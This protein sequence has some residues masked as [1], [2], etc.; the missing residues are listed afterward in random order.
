MAQTCGLGPIWLSSTPS[1]VNFAVE[2]EQCEGKVAS[3]TIYLISHGTDEANIY[4]ISWQPE[5]PAPP[6]YTTS[7]QVN[8]GL[9]PTE[10]REGAIDFYPKTAGSFFGAMVVEYGYNINALN[11]M[12]ACL[13]DI[14]GT[15]IIRLQHLLEE[16]QRDGPDFS[17]AATQ[18]T[19]AKLIATAKYNELDAKKSQAE[20]KAVALALEKERALRDIDLG[21]FC[22][23]CNRS[24]TQIE[25]ED[26]KSFEEHLI[27]VH[28]HAI[29]GDPKVKAETIRKYDILIDAA[30]AEAATVAQ[31]IDDL[32][33]NLQKQYDA[34]KTKKIEILTAFREKETY[35]KQQID[36]AKGQWR[37]AMDAFGREFNNK[38]WYLRVMI[39]GTCREK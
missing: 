6:F 8:T 24:R 13:N 27:D 37:Q 1:K 32:R 5:I 19:R 38:R 12:R 10:S 9:R 15:N 11:K 4:G 34:I 3:E 20:K 2:T 16:L 7:W 39:D 18:E 22:S 35:L 23:Q 21:L 36:D 31:Q 14:H 25:R 30:N 26:K 17:E 29:P 33:S 28:G